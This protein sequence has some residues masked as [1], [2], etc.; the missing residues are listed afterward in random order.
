[1]IQSS[2]TANVRYRFYAR[3][4]HAAVLVL[5]NAEEILTALKQEFLYLC[6]DDC[7]SSNVVAELYV[8]REG[9]VYHVPSTDDASVRNGTLL[10]A[11][12]CIGHHVTRLLVEANAD[13]L[14]LHAGAV[15][16]NGHTLLVV[17]ASGSGKS[18]LV[19]ALTK[20][21]WQYLSDEF[22]PLEPDTLYAIP[23]PIAPAPR[24]GPSKF[25]P[26]DLVATLPKRT[27]AL[28]SLSVC[29]EP[30]PI[31]SIV[32]PIFKPDSACE[33]RACTSTDVVLELLRGSPSLVLDPNR[34]LTGMSRLVQHAAGFRLRYRR[35]S[36]AAQLVDEALASHPGQ[37]STL[38]V[39]LVR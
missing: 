2:P 1:M 31:S 26:L 17:G 30:Q 10:D 12:R 37:T 22:V 9:G 38:P 23:F 28:T 39:D 32:L 25:L 20:R 15:A 11:V 21:G 18:T 24:I 14:W 6:Q 16:R 3:F 5:T 34:T 7:I 35:G 13:F 4:H 33:L 36:E 8:I 27:T 19:T 29:R